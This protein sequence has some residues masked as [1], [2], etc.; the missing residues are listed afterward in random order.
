MSADLFGEA[1]Q[2]I[3]PLQIKRQ[4]EREPRGYAAA[5]GSGPAGETCK[6]CR[7]YVIK[8]MAQAY[9]KCELRR[10]A[11]TGGAG[12]D[13]RASSPACSKWASP[14]AT[15]DRVSTSPADASLGAAFS[16]CKRYRYRLWRNFSWSNL[17]NKHRDLV[18]VMLNP[19]AANALDNDPTVERC[20]RRARAMKLD[21]VQVVNLFAL[22]ST[23][24]RGIYEADD[25]VGP[26]N[27]DAILK[28][29]ISARMVICAWGTHGAL[30]GRGQQVLSMLR[31]AG[32]KPHAL[33]LNN[34]G[35]PAH[36]LYLRGD[37]V[38]FPMEAA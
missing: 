9:R 20:E 37:L 23:D 32:I 15:F 8:Q 13:V 19:S 18:F 26:E 2:Q 38:P 31:A 29:C 28:A 11:W 17:P 30:H 3:A 12:T 16:D 34:D 7:Y 24:P 5:P 4:R 14:E 35:S 6:S 36:P 27:D 25:P 33:K 10:A 22:R 1:P 21:G